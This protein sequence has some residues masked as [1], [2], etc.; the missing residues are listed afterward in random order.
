MRDNYCG[1]KSDLV[2]CSSIAQ[3][4]QVEIVSIKLR[5]NSLQLV[6]I[7][8][9]TASSPFGVDGIAVHSED[10][11]SLFSNRKKTMLE[12]FPFAEIQP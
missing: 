4:P 3:F 2:R 6:T 1:N 7:T 12:R 10:D 5:G 11:L 9:Q 8:R